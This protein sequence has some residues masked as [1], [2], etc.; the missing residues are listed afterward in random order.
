M[1]DTPL[2][3][4]VTTGLLVAGAAGAELGMEMDGQ[5]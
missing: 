4:D 2:E 5:G 3:V 1:T